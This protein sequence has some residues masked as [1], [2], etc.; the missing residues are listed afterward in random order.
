MELVGMPINDIIGNLNEMKEIEA[1][2]F[3]MCSHIKTKDR[4]D[5]LNDAIYYLVEIKKEFDRRDDW[6]RID[7]IFK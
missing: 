4:M 7:M 6:E 2:S 3:A 1:V 5:A